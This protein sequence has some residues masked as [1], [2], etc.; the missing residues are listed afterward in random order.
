MLYQQ[1]QSGPA[2]IDYT[3]PITRG[4]LFAYLPGFQYDATRKF[5]IAAINT[6]FPVRQSASLFLPGGSSNG[7]KLNSVP[8]PL[9][10]ALQNSTIFALVNPGAVARTNSAFY[11][12]RDST[13]I[14]KLESG[15]GGAQLTLRVDNGTLIQLLAT[16]AA[17]N[18]G[19]RHFFA[20]MRNGTAIT[21]LCDDVVNTGTFGTSSSAMTEANIVRTIGYDNTDGAAFS[22]GLYDLVIGFDRALSMAEYA[23]LRANPWQIFA[24]EDDDETPKVATGGPQSYSYTATGGTVFSG[25]AAVLRGCTK[26]AVGGLVFSGAAASSR[27]AAKVATGGLIFS[28]AA[29]TTR[30]VAR[31]PS[32]GL[33]FS[34]AAAELRS[35]A[36]IPSGGLVFGGAATIS[37]GTGSQSR[38]VVATGGIVFSG[39]AALV[40]STNRTGTGGIRF[41]GTAPVEF[42]HA[43]V[44]GV[45]DWWIQYIRRR[46]RR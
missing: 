18:D 4:L 37:T 25:A 27:T 13:D 33:V 19:K 15:T 40:R 34:G 41:A 42:V 7:L 38:V 32:G 8:G 14:Y 1:P 31:T 46:G 10:G 44:G 2:F 29:A 39:T 43:G 45:A 21:A 16:N 17:W 6:T 35:V 26:A 12:E 24:D 9:L 23:S 36:R 11:C 28:G 20:A 22:G 3:N 5:P 30:S